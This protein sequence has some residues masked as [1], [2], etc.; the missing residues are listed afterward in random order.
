MNTSTDA[1]MSTDGAGQPACRVVVT[2]IGV[3]APNGT[4]KQAFWRNSLRETSHL[5]AL[6]RFPTGNH[7]CRIAGQVADFDAGA[8]IEHGVRRQ[9]DRST[10]MALASCRMATEDAGLDLAREDPQRIGM[11]F[12]NTFGGME[13]A[14]PELYNQHFV[15]PSRVSAYQSI[16]W[17]FAAAQGQ[18]SI[19]NGLKG[20]AK[21]IVADRVGGH[22]ALLFGA[23]AIRQRRADVVYAGGFEAPLAPYVFRIHES[24]GLLNTGADRPDTAYRP[25]D[26]NRGGIVL[27]EGCA[28][29]M[30]E[31]LGRARMRGA[32]IYAELAGGAITHDV[33]ADAGSHR[34]LARCLRLALDA[35]DMTAAEID[36]VMPE[37]LADNDNDRREAAA[38]DEVFGR[39]GPRVA[40]P[41]ARIGHTLAAAGAIDATWASLMIRERTMLPRDNVCDG[42]TALDFGLDDTPQPGPRAVLCFGSG[43][44]GINTGL[45]LRSA[46]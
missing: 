7:G 1:V 26:R 2:G 6:D 11:F 23:L 22:Q 35:A 12:A 24:T 9:T 36:C 16:A 44:G 37:G 27:G 40:V 42:D 28:I 38:I 21:S 4:G 32:T 10:H 39:G 33:G 45:V 29:L 18:W 5:R 31:E 8:F 17:F 30:L 3:V 43:H 34:G 41:K 13:F 14:E 25:F 20:F 19:A 46:A 15:G